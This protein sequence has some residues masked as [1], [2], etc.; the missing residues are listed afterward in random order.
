MRLTPSQIAIRL[1]CGCPM[2]RG[3]EEQSVCQR[4]AEG[5][6]MFVNITGQDFG[7]DLQAWHDHLK[8]TRQGGYTYGRNI[9]LPKIMQ[10]ALAS[11]E[12]HHAVE[13]LQSTDSQL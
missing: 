10:E 4:I 7:Y 12:W 2:H 3:F 6:R 9:T 1:I 13:V 11:E 8:E 5:H